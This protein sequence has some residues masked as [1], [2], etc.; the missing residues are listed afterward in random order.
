MPLYVYECPIC[1]G[2]RSD[3]RTVDD[4]HA[5]PTCDKCN[6]PMILVPQAVPGIVR[7]PAVPRRQR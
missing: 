1:N 6:W 5:G 7:N 3:M 2:Q 4:R